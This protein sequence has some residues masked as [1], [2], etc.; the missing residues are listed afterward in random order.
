MTN[1]KA[2]HTANV[3]PVIS[4]RAVIHRCVVAND[5]KDLHNVAVFH[6]YIPHIVKLYTDYYCRTC[7]QTA[8]VYW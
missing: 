8:V 3:M 2:L 4:L 1:D 5:T 6:Q 7:T